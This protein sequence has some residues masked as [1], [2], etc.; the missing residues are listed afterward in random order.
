MQNVPSSNEQTINE[1][2]N[3]IVELETQLHGTDNINVLLK[4]ENEELKYNTDN[5]NCGLYVH[6]LEKKIVCN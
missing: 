5:K 2:S 3:K 1:L 6:E 4:K